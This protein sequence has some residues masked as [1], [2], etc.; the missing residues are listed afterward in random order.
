VLVGSNK[1][2][3]SFFPV[4]S[5]TEQFEQQGRARWGGLADDYLKLYSHATDAEASKSAADS[6]N[7]GA[8]WHMRMYADY[9][10]KR[11]NKAWLYYFAQNPPAPADNRRSPLRMRRKCRTSS[12]ISAR[13]RCFRTT[14]SR[15][16]P[17]PRRRT[18]RSR[19]RCRRTG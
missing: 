13:C 11:G 18:R 10:V 16:F 19:I 5:T 2:D 12:I 1:D 14:V 9:Q 17:R 7:D 15:L 4:K 8:F 3:L 6:S